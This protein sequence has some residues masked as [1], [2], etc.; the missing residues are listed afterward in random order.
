MAQ[1]TIDTTE[2]NQGSDSL[3]QELDTIVFKEIQSFNQ[4]SLD[5]RAVFL[6]DFYSETFLWIGKK[7]QDKDRLIVYP[8]AF[9]HLSILHH[10]HG[11]EI[12]ERVSFSIVESGYEPE[13]FKS[14]FKGWQNFDHTPS[15][16]ATIV[17]EDSEGEEGEKMVGGV[18]VI[19]GNKRAANLL[20]ENIW[21]N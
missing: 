14:A 6:L 1:S 11:K 9:Q 15:S 19:V 4:K 7:V 3:T 18:N 21:I 5:D 13:V 20:P 2:N 8:L 16:A 10:P 12:I 17:E